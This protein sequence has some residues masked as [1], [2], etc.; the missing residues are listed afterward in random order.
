[1]MLRSEN[2]NIE[3]VGF[4]QQEKKLPN[5]HR[6]ADIFVPL[7]TLPM[8]IFMALYLNDYVN[9]TSKSPGEHNENRWKMLLMCFLMLTISLAV[10]IYIC[11]RLN[12]V[13]GGRSKIG[14]PM[15]RSSK[16]NASFLR[17]INSDLQN[18][19]PIN[20]YPTTYDSITFNAPSRWIPVEKGVITV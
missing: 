11:M 17:S 15:F 4:Y 16:S 14:I 12:T 19:A 9:H 7:F 10:F 3:T 8:L 2:Y 1:M 6:Y 5:W 20:N 13:R 18:A